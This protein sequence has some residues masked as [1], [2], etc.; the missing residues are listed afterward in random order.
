M[1]KNSKKLVL[2]VLIIVIMGAVILI[3][4]LKSVNG[5]EE[6]DVMCI[7]NNSQLFVLKTC[8]HCAK[9]KEI[10]GDYLK[11]FNMTDCIENPKECNDYNITHVP[12]WVIN[13]QK[14][15]GIQTLKQLK[16]LAGC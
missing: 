6:K 11:Y 1:N 2:I 3:Y 8:S 10:L 13:G 15:E 5:V 4:N 16:E 14:Y 9:Q 12:S 7:S